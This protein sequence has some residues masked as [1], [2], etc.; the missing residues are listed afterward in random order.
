MKY[1]VAISY[2]NKLCELQRS[3]GIHEEFIRQYLDDTFR[4][5]YSTLAR[6]MY[7]PRFYALLLYPDIYFQEY[8]NDVDPRLL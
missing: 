6:A 4:V 7:F 8:K 2:Y 5:N 3:F 1:A